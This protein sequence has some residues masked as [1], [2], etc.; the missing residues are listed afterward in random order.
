MRLR[1]AAVLAGFTLGFMAGAAKADLLHFEYEDPGEPLSF[2]LDRTPSPLANDAESFSVRA[3]S[4]AVYYGQPV[5]Y[6]DLVFL[7]SAAGGGFV[8]DYFP[9]GPLGEIV[10][11]DQ[12]F[13]GSTT[14]PVFSPGIFRLINPLDEPVTLVISVVPLPASAPMFGA[15]LLGLAGLGYAANRRKAAAA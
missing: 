15:A 8:N 5:P 1:Y 4:K 12:L 3:S 2:N 7:T 9:G 13:S 14:H 6:F 11:G 10:S